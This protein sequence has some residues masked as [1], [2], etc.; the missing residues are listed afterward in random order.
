MLSKLKVAEYVLYY[1]IYIKVKICKI[2]GIVIILS[3]DT[4]HDKT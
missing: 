1:T 3:F 4:T 2:K